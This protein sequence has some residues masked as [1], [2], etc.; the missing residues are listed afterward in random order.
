MD[1]APWI[2]EMDFCG[3]S[4]CDY[5]LCGEREAPKTLKI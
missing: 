2:V 3:Y 1:C 5:W 4:F